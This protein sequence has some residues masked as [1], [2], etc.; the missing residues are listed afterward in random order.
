MGGYINGCICSEKPVVQALMGQLQVK[1]TTSASFG[2]GGL[3]GSNIGWV[4]KAS[5]EFAE[6]SK[7]CRVLFKDSSSKGLDDSRVLLG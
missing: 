2:D 1:R 5:G 4:W 6:L 3:D 7:F